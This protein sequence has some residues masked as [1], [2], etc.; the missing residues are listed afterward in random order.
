LVLLRKD[1]AE[2]PFS[3]DGPLTWGELDQVRT[4]VFTP[5]LVGLLPAGPVRPGDGWT[6][7]TAAIRELTDLESID[8]GRIDCRLESVTELDRRRHARINF[9]GSVRGTNEDGPNQ[10]TLDGYLYFDLESNHLSYLYLKGLSV[11]LDKEG[12]E[13]GRMEGRFV[14]TRRAHTR[15]EELSD[16]TLKGRDL[17][18]NADN[19]LLLYDN[20]DLGVRFHHPRRWRI[21]AV[22][23]T[24]VTLDSTD[25]SGLLI[26]I[27]PPERAPTGPQFL[28]ETRDWLAGQK[29]RV[30]RV[31]PVQRVLTDPPLEHFALEIEMGNQRALMDYYIARQRTGGATLAARLL[32]PN[33]AALQIEVER[34]ARSLVITRK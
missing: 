17:E 25:G 16:A 26:T 1:N 32:P 21:G 31:E 27:E 10:Q 9:A 3:P 28:N 19:T 11:L 7:S 34:V 33:T 23:G 20:P 22:R 24:Q 5:A 12:R 6:A 30:L 4:D 8:Q 14:L 29:A 18:P 2:V 15:C 13:V